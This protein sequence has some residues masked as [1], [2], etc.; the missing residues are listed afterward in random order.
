MASW[1]ESDSDVEEQMLRTAH[2]LVE[3]K[4]KIEAAGNATSREMGDVCR[5]AARFLIQRFEQE[6]D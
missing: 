2:C 4:M 1:K 3:E 6:L 5:A